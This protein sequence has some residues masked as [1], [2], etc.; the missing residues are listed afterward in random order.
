MR[1][2]V[3][4]KDESAAT[5]KS[6]C[7]L[8]GARGM[9][10]RVVVGSFRQSMLDEF[11]GA[12]P[13]VATSASTLEASKFLALYRAGLAA[14]YS[15]PMQA[16]QVPEYAGGMTV[17]TRGFVEAAHA[18]NLHVHVWTV[19]DPADMRRLLGEG[20]DGVMTDYPDRLLAL[21]GRR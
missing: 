7:G 15:P 19:N 9:A 21:L 12:C 11:R 8:A 2:V 18:R 1:F 10:E 3:E 4:M 16:L 20:V 17:I 14:S 5:V 6:L 13:Q